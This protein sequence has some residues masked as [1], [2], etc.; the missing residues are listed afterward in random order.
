MATRGI[1]IDFEKLPFPNVY[2]ADELIEE[3]NK[4]ETVNYKSFIDKYCEFD[5]RE[6]TKLI[7]KC[8]IE[9]KEDGIVNNNFKKEAAKRPKKIQRYSMM[10]LICIMIIYLVVLC[11]EVMSS[12]GAFFG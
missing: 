12:L 10:M 6:S 4:V 5:N 3:S 7:C 9:G 1:Y 11:T 8:V 2:N